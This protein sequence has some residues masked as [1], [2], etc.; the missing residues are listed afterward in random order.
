MDTAVWINGST[1]VVYT[2]TDWVT[3]LKVDTQSIDY[4]TLNVTARSA[5]TIRAEFN[6]NN[7]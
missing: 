5:W 6:W 3:C 1:W 7:Y 4:I 2:G